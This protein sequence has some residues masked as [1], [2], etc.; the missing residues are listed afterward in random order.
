VACNGTAFLVV[1]KLGSK[2]NSE[3]VSHALVVYAAE[4]GSR[5]KVMELIVLA[6]GAR[7]C[8]AARGVLPNLPLVGPEGEAAE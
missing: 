7:V 3:C 4:I 1:H 8:Y 6:Y 2:L 5:N